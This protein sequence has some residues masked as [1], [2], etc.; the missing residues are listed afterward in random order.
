[1]NGSVRTNN[2]PARPGYELA[3]LR[4]KEPFVKRLRRLQARMSY[5]SVN[6]VKPHEVQIIRCR[7]VEHSSRL[8]DA[9]HFANGRAWVWNVLDRFAG[10]NDVE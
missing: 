4:E 5:G 8:A 2:F 1:M 10:D 3:Y 7:E 6:E 9:V